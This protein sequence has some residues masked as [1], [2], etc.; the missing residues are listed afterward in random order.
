MLDL[1]LLFSGKLC[2]SLSPLVQA[3]LPEHW[4]FVDVRISPEHAIFF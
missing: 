3:L 2:L 1:R 4:N